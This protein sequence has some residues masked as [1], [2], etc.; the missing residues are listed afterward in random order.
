[1][2]DY[3][4]PP[5][6]QMQ[7]DIPGVN[8]VAREKWEEA[9][10]WTCRHFAEWCGYKEFAF[11]NRGPDGKASPNECLMFLRTTYRLSIP[12]AWAPILA[13]LA[14]QECPRLEFRIAKSMFDPCAEVV[15][16]SRRSPSPAAWTA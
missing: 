15:L 9:R 13:R 4:P 16:R 12:N 11:E 10:D 5:D 7:L 2:R 3:G 6:N 1:M 8:D 14:M